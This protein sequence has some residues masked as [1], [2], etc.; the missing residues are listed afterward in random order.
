MLGIER[1]EY[2]R[3]A[4]NDHLLNTLNYKP[5]SHEEATQLRLEALRKTL[6]LVT[7][8]L[9]PDSEDVKYFRRSFGTTNSTH[10]SRSTLVIFRLSQ[11]YLTPKVHKLP[12]KF[13]PVISKSGSELEILSVWL[14]VQL[15]RV[16][17]L[18]PGYLKDN[19]TLIRN[20][21]DI[22]GKLPSNAYFVTADAVGMY[23]NIDT[24][25]GL[26]AMQEWFEDLHSHELP[27]DYPT[28][29]IL[30]G[31]EIVMRL[32]VFGFGNTFWLQLRG[33]AMG[34][35]VA[36][37]YATIYYSLH[38]ETAIAPPPPMLPRLN[39]LL[40]KRFIDDAIFL[41]T[42]DDPA[43]TKATIM[44]TMNNFGPPGKQL[45][46]EVSD[47]S[48]SI[49]FLD[50]TLSITEQGEIKY[51]TYQK[52]MNLYLYIPRMSAHPES[53][54]KSFIQSAIQRYWLQNSDPAD[55][56]SILKLFF[57]HLRA[58][59]YPQEELKQ[60]FIATCRQIDLK[61]PGI[62]GGP[63]EP[64][65]AATTTTVATTPP[66]RQLYLHTEYHPNSVPRQ[67]IH[68]AFQSTIGQEGLVGEGPP[69]A[70]TIAYARAPNIGDTA[71]RT[72]LIQQGEHPLVSNHLQQPSQGLL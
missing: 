70:L 6:D 31:L 39:L 3:H 34:T 60:L 2:I 59:G 56:Q 37:M 52:P 54:F 9:H 62:P 5:L 47:L 41:L 48:R 63:A 29:T 72:T 50:L 18:C 36:V 19:W 61:Q 1:T 45:V 69:L 58:R 28:K 33:T 13:R 65:G 32:N 49:N 11:F 23:S 10:V 8:S 21:Q 55:F 64:S 25:H 42:S 35:S 30:N 26:Q 17:H 68:K 14:D 46:W 66:T 20:L 4:L 22:D 12:L 40:S 44:E 43:A 67:M 53:V 27:K 24:D 71:V 38:E 16:K 7:V 51:Q 15:Q 57:L